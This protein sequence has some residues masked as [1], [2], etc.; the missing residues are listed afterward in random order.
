M[1]SK[2][3]TVILLSALIT[4]I[5][6]N[7]P[8]KTVSFKKAQLE[9][10]IIFNNRVFENIDSNGVPM[11]EVLNKN[12]LLSSTSRTMFILGHQVIDVEIQSNRVE[13][14]YT[15]SDTIGYSFYDF[16]KQVVIKFDSLHSDARI[17]KKGD[18]HKDGSFN[19]KE[20]DPMNGV[21]DSL[22]SRKDTMFDRRRNTLIKFVPIDIEDTAFARRAKFWI[23]PAFVNFPLQMSYL[24][25]QKNK[26]EFVYK[27]QLAF[28]DGKAVMVTSFDYHPDKL[29]DT[30]V[31][32]F[33]KWSETM[34]LL[35]RNDDRKF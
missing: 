34:S 1:R 11:N 22:W 24:L 10:Y 2:N 27:Q 31:T 6:C 20:N 32:I 7:N 21:S 25:S 17:L 30:L 8:S 13:G 35:I 28:P 23:D 5:Q 26:N 29:P 18:M 15:H 3:I 9:G 16:D 4:C 14:I 19:A 12:I 33:K